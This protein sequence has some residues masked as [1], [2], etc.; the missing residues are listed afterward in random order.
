M[1]NA[2]QQQ[3]A[4][5][6]ASLVRKQTFSGSGVWR[7]SGNAT[8]RI[9]TQTNSIVEAL[10][11][12]PSREEQEEEERES[13]R[14]HEELVGA[15][16]GDGASS[17][18]TGKK[19]GLLGGLMSGV[20]KLGKGLA[21]PLKGLFGFLGSVSK[22]FTSIG[23]FLLKPI[24][25][26]VGGVA[27][28]LGTAITF[29]SKMFLGLAGF[30]ALI[31]GIGIAAATMSD[32]EF[33]EFKDSIAKGVAG[34]ISKVVDGAIKIW[35]EFTP[36]SWNISDET[37]KKFTDATFTNVSSVITSVIDFAKDLADSFGA[38]FKTQIEGFGKSWDKFKETFDKIVE[39]FKGSEVAEGAKGGLVSVAETVGKTVGQIAT[40]FLDL[41]TALGQA[42]LGEKVDVDNKF[43]TSAA[44]I[45]KGIISFISDVASSFKEGFEGKFDKIS[46]SFT[47]LKAS[48]GK[49]VD[50][51]TGILSDVGNKNDKGKG[52]IAGV[53]NMLGSAVGGLISGILDIATGVANLIANPT[54]TLAR[55]QAN[56]ED[57]F[58]GIGQ[59]IGRLFDKFFNFEFILTLLPQSLQDAARGLGLQKRAAEKRFE[60]KKK[61]ID[62]AE[63]NIKTLEEANRINEE[64]LKKEQAKGD[65]ADKT[66]LRNLSLNIQRNKNE[67]AREEENIEYAQEAA[68]RSRDNIIQEEVNDR[69]E[70]ATNIDRLGKLEDIK[71]RED[72]INEYMTTDR[73]GS[74][75]GATVSQ[76]RQLKQFVDKGGDISSS[77][78]IALIQELG[79]DRDASSFKSNEALRKGITG[80]DLSAAESKIAQDQAIITRLKNE[81]KAQEADLIPRIREQVMKEMGLTRQTGGPISATGSYRLHAGEMVMDNIAAS[82]MLTASQIMSSYLPQSGTVINQLQMDRTMGG[83]TG[84]AAPVVIDNSQQPTIINQTNVAAPQTRGPA[85]VGEGRDKVNM[86]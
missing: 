31:G 5:D 41:G 22:I 25:W 32:K 40:F 53:A 16:K 27:G 34:A 78:G 86:R 83:T 43:I 55:I 42:A 62:A 19:G 52:T 68:A 66:K 44:K 3:M 50:K 73:I 30:A 37:R 1:A 72:E 84:S 9:Q 76:A 69:F 85:L 29:I 7:Q 74:G 8:L 6:I 13:D 36:D 79:L 49:V 47:E 82:Q 2:L 12:I 14:Q 70:K 67:I 75:Y 28:T 26:L 81:L 45:I 48:I 51:F 23:G 33:E 65:E 20:G 77:A 11:R 10:G 38:G 15:L 17:G 80:K 46:E 59:T 24:K 64:R 60:E 61:E 35:N 4:D 18:E 54:E 58:F 57:F 21:K 56:I 39:A 71:D 63:E